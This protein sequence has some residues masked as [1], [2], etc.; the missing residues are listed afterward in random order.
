MLY[1]DVDEQNVILNCPVAKNN[2]LRAVKQKP[3]NLH[4]L[5]KM[6]GHCL[7]NDRPLNNQLL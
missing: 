6:Q 7:R 2:F 4:L 1:A 3:D 5:Q